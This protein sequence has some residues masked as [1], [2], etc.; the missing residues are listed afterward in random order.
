MAGCRFVCVVYLGLVM[1][2]LIGVGTP[3]GLQGRRIAVIAARVTLLRALWHLAARHA[4]SGTRFHRSRFASPRAVR[5]N[6]KRPTSAGSV[7]TK[8]WELPG[9]KD[10]SRVVR[11]FRAPKDPSRVVRVF[12]GPKNPSRVVRV[13]RG[14]KTPGRVVRVFRG[15]S[16]PDPCCPRNPWPN[17]SGIP[18]LACG[19][20][21]DASLRLREPPRFRNESDIA[22]WPRSPARR[23]PS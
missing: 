3:R 14:P 9:P 10:P 12:R 6:S 7:S 20:W 2:Q 5:S 19:P 23:R 16:H 18:R 15:Q 11:V 17:S 1:R 13:F 22:P 8:S 4:R 21:R